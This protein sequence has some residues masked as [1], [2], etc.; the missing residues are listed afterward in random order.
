MTPRIHC[1]ANDP[2]ERAAIDWSDWTWGQISWASQDHGGSSTA[3]LASVPY[4]R[5]TQCSLVS[6]Q[7]LIQDPIGAQTGGSGSWLCTDPG[8]SGKCRLLP[9]SGRDFCLTKIRADRFLKPL[10]VILRGGCRIIGSSVVPVLGASKPFRPSGVLAR[11]EVVTPVRLVTVGHE[12][13]REPSHARRALLGCRVQS[14]D[15][16]HLLTD[17]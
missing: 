17:G 4:I 2:G 15:L 1:S 7:G 13:T 12:G 14:R 6:Q 11:F 10:P 16:P 3:A 9:Q 5:L 8:R